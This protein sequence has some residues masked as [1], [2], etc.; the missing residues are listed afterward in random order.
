MPRAQLMRDGEPDQP[1]AHHR[2]ADREVA[3]GRSASRPRQT[4][5]AEPR[6]AGEREPD[7]VER[8]RGVPCARWG[9]I[10][11]RAA[12]NADTVPSGTLMREDPASSEA[13][14]VMM[15]LTRGATGATRRTQVSRAI[16]M[17][18]V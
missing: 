18:S 12:M 8:R 2:P 14:V 16:W 5:G 10:R 3:P 4:S 6:G 1:D 11:R 17:R 13:V 15:P 9:I 7:P